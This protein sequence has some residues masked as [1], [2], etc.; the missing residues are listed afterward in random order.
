LEKG[1]LSD[2]T[3]KEVAEVMDAVKMVIIP[4]GS[5]EQHGPHLPLKH[6]AA[7]AFYVAERLAEALYPRVLV[8]PAI[9]FGVSYHH[10]HFP[11]T[12]SVSPNTLTSLIADICESFVSHGV[13]NFLIINGHGGN[14]ETLSTAVITVNRRLGVDAFFVNY[15]DFLP[16]QAI[17]NKLVEDEKVPGHSADFETSIAL[18]IYPKWFA[19]TLS[20]TLTMRTL[21]Y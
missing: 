18:H 8:T 1:V 6:D 20:K 5:T 17:N 21:N 19:C 14:F 12:I 16:K 7:S 3:W 11:G 10:M 15:W 2:M 9:P 13:R 4:V